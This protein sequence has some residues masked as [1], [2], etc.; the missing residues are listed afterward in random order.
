M[1]P[2]FHAAVQMH[3]TGRTRLYRNH[4]VFLHEILTSPFRQPEPQVALTLLQPDE[5]RDVRWGQPEGP[6]TL[7]R[8]DRKGHGRSGHSKSLDWLLGQ[9]GIGAFVPSVSGHRSAAGP[10]TFSWLLWW[11]HFRSAYHAEPCD[12]MARCG[13]GLCY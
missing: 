7:A 2:G 4:I 9:G 12:T 6:T 5:L 13:S 10:P 1:I 3:S 11:R 8:Q